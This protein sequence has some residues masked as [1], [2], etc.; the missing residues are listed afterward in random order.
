[1][2]EAAAGFGD[3]DLF[4]V[5]KNLA[6]A[7]AA[8]KLVEPVD[9]EGIYLQLNALA[10][11]LDELPRVPEH[12]FTHTPPTKSVRQ[13]EIT[14]DW[15]RRLWA[16]IKAMAGMLNDYIKIEDV[17][18]PAQPLVD[19]YTSQVAILNLR[20]LIEQAQVALLKEQGLIYRQSLEQA[21]TLMNEYFIPSPAADKV[22]QSLHELAQ[23]DIAPSLPDISIALQQLHDYV[24]KQRRSAAAGA[25]L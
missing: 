4:A 19:Q 22:K 20:L 13:P 18:A 15:W 14:D 2:A 12:S 11:S 21:E 10:H 17:N 25:S 5:R 23:L 3:P 6:A 16:E 8:L 7:V 24:R 1:L 9:R